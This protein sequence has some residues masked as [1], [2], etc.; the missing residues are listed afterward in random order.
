MTKLDNTRISLNTSALLSTRIEGQQ[1]GGR[2]IRTWLSRRY[3]RWL[4]EC[5]SIFISPY[6]IVMTH[7]RFRWVFCQL[8]VLR[9]CFPPSVRRILDELPDSLDETYE[10]VLREIKKANQGIAHRLL[11]CLVAAVRPLRVEELA[12]VLAF[13]FTTKSIPKLN[14]SWRWEDQEEAVMSACSSLVIVVKDRYSRIVQFSH[15]SVK[16]YLTSERLS[17]SNRDVSR[18][19]ILLEPA[20]TILAQG[21]LGVLLRLDDRADRDSI[22]SFPLARYAAKYWYRHAQFGSVSSYV[23]DEMECLFDADKPHFATWLWIYG[24]A[25]FG[26]STCRPRPQKPTAVPLYHAARLGFRD[27]VEH[28]VAEHPDDLYAKG[29]EGTPLHFFARRGQIEA[30]SLLI[31]HLTNVDILGEDDRSPLHDASASGHLEIG[32][33]LLSHGADVNFRDDT[34]WTPLYRAALLGQLECVRMLLE[35][36]AAID[37]PDNQ[38][39]TPLFVASEW[40]RVEVVRLLL[41]YGADPNACKVDGKRPFYM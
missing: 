26:R 17:E 38:G 5:K 29:N 18:Y 27:L 34:G 25:N 10:R 36:G 12:E 22:K 24:K 31:E 32:Q 30:V 6:T 37:A 19:Q 16:E 33:L 3:P 1:D 7:R 41:E 23:K 20:H 35:H 21:C 2:R 8:Q 39:K 13:D 14:P 40:G 28:L 15:F 11:Q 4:M 9:Y